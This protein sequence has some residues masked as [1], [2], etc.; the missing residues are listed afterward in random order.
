MRS[1]RTKSTRCPPQ[2]SNADIQMNFV[3]LHFSGEVLKGSGFSVGSFVCKSAITISQNSRSKDA[4]PAHFVAVVAAS[5]IYNLAIANH[6]YALQNQSSRHLKQALLYYE[7]SYKIQRQEPLCYNP[8]HVLCILNNVAMIHRRMGNERESA[9]YL[10][11]LYTT[12]SILDLTGEREAQTHWSGL[13]SNVFCLVSD[14]PST[15]AAA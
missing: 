10:R 9:M 6:L 15:A 12:M 1:S 5:A 2:Q 7:I 3:D 4:P 8:T 11:R 14:L 13:W